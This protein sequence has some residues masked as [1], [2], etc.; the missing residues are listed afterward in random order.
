MAG[1]SISGLGSSLDVESII[2]NLM[3]IEA[4]PRARLELRQSQAKAREEALREVSSKLQAVSDAATALR[5]ST[6]WD[7]V[8]TVQSSAPDGVAARVL[9]GTGPG[10][11]Q[12][13]VNQLAR[14]EQRTFDFTASGSPSQ[15]TVNGV[16]V[17][18]GAGAT[19]KDAAAAINAN[20]ETGVYAVAVGSQLVLSSR[21]TGAANTIAAG[22]A[23]IAEVAAKLK[24]GQDAAY[25]VDGVAATSASNVVTD[26][27]P[28]LEL[29]LKSVTAAAATVSVGNP[30]P[31]GNALQSKLKAFVDSY[32]A[33][34]DTIR[35]KLT[36]TRVPQPSTAAEAKKGVLFGDTQLSGLLGRMRQFVDE[37]GISALGVDT[38]APG[39][40]VSADSDAVIG[41]LALDATKLAAALE[42]GPAGAR[43]TISGKGGFGEAFAGLLAPTLGTGGTISGRLDAVSGESK[44]ISE[45]MTAL[46]A[47]LEQREERLHM[48][49]AKLES[50]LLANQTQSSWLSGQLGQLGS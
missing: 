21:K 16:N 11:Y 9:S 8:Q 34:V 7:D 44:R 36:E 12:V 32:N 18:L 14:A 6:L 45:S 50:A 46:S 2:A 39:S 33:A 5:S 29:T 38:G 15:I 10:G 43:K 31:D 28:G 42:T 40:A 3:K 47:R 41:H 25:E 22:G 35:G 20:S 48:Q 17:E 37:S 19:L 49:F 24:A 27:V 23:G 13:K 4:A 26:A 1:I 30:G